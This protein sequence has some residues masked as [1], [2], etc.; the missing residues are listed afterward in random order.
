MRALA[1]T[2]AVVAALAATAGRARAQAE[3]ADRFYV[4]KADEDRERT[5]WQGS[6]TSS[7]FYYAEDGTDGSPY[8]AGGEPPQN[9]SPFA[10]MWTELRAQVD[11]RHLK[12]GRWDLRLDTRLRYVPDPINSG[13][14]TSDPTRIQSGLLGEHE[15]EL[16]ELYLVRGGRRTD[17]FVG[18]QIIADLGAIK[19]DGLRIDYA[20]NRRWTYLGFAGLYPARGS[21]SID[22]DYRPG[23]DKANQPTGRVLPVAGGFGGAYR[24]QNSY[25]ALGAVAIVPTSRD[26]GLGGNG[27]F[28][29]PRLYLTANGYWRRSA[30]LDVWHYVIL[31]LYGSA[32]TT[33]T[34]ASAGLQYKPSAR[35]RFQLWANHLNTEAL[36]VQVRDQLEN[37]AL[38]DGVVVNNIKV[39]RIGTTAARASVSALLG[40]G[41]RFELTAALQG[42]RRPEVILEAGAVDQ[43]LP[44]ARSLDL[45]VQAVDRQFY[46]GVRLEG[47]FIRTIGVGDASYARS[48]AQIVR[49]GGARELKDG[50]AQ[51]SGDLSWITTADDNATMV[52]LPTNLTSC[53]G[54]ANTTALQA[55]AVGYYRWK[56]DWFVTGTLGAGT[57]KMIVTGMGGAG[58]GQSTTLIGQAYLRV[59]Y[60]F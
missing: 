14:P 50:K 58:V 34:N 28:E 13:R 52:C 8:V 33:P 19:I 23:I 46:G 3:E 4:D 9:G 6:L 49:L 31:D 5:L 42:R 26:G 11:G 53:Y 17:L 41:R 55:N 48:T 37:E 20:K 54:A 38:L 29:R 59:G 32:G 47:S 18:R 51:L 15:Y 45:H 36:N 27:T 60:R 21:R 10:R 7:S 25:G 12:G 24:T 1:L 30:R 44:S 57:Q 22:S 35:L 2:A 56:T 40:K 43:V 39:Q 16:R